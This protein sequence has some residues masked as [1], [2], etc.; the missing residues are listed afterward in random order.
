[1]EEKVEKNIVSE[2]QEEKSVKHGQQDFMHILKMFSPGTS[3]R[4]ALEDILRARMGALI[5]F[6][7]PGIFD[8][9][10]GGFRVNCRFSSQR[11]SE[12]AKMDGAIIVAS[13][14]NAL[15]S[16]RRLAAVSGVPRAFT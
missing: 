5:V 16:V 3:L 9:V 6:E 2:Y 15:V 13:E 4:T 8:I 12:L 7:K 10:D 11:L 1:M 14:F